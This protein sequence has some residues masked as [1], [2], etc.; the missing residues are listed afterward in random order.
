[1]GWVSIDAHFEILRILRCCSPFHPAEDWVTRSRGYLSNLLFTFSM[2]LPS[3]GTHFFSLVYHHYLP[4][5]WSFV[6]PN[7]H[8]ITLASHSKEEKNPNFWWLLVFNRTAPSLLNM[9]FLTKSFTVW[10]QFI[11][12]VLFSMWI[13]F[14]QWFSKNV[15]CYLR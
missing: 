15:F 4:T 1:M 6:P 10:R 7:H 2:A 3:S 8:L 5:N 12:L 13:S 11:F 9:A 14:I